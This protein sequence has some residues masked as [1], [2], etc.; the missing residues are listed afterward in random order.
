MSTALA[1]ALNAGLRDAMEADDKIVLIGEDIGSLGGV[2]RVTDGLRKDFG[3]DRVVTSPL[4]EAGI[5]GSAIGLA[6][7]GYRPVC[8][9]QFDGFVFPAMN[10]IVT[11]LA[12]YRHRS[13]GMVSLPVVIRIPVGGGI[14][15]IEHHS[16]SPE[17][18][19]AHTPGL[20]VLCPSDA[21]DAYDLLGQAI[22][23]NDPV[24]FLEPKR[25]YWAKGEVDPS[26]PSLP[27]DLARIVRPGG[28]LTLVT[29]GALVPLALTTAAILAEEGRDVEVIDLRSLSPIDDM[30]VVESVRRTGRLVIA[31]EA[32]QTGGIGGELASRVQARA[33]YEIE[34]PILRVTG[35]DTPYP[36]S[37]LEGDWLPNVDRLLEACDLSLSH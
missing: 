24:V 37:R 1:H 31:H 30:T 14:G 26:A 19:F 5:V 11:Q 12:K 15:A 7:A 16:E 4:G 23:C 27:M 28:D 3:E 9:I 34:A 17:A 8:E 32:P 6:L 21:Q 36:P 2:F 25:S 20:R 35:Y 29:Y 10:Q 18:Y 33:F 13:E 22:R